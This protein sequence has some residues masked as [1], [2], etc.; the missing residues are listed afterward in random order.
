MELKGFIDSYTKKNRRCLLTS[1]KVHY[2]WF[3]MFPT[4]RGKQGIVFKTLKGPSTSLILGTRNN[5]IPTE[6]GQ[7]CLHNKKKENK[8]NLISSQ[9]EG[10]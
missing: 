2:S 4:K 8:V 10:C 1:Y 5:A 6:H 7:L 9:K 3:T